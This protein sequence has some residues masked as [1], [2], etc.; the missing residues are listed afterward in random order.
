MTHDKLKHLLRGCRDGVSNHGYVCLALL[1][2]GFCY[3]EA[4]CPDEAFGKLCEFTYSGVYSWGAQANGELGTGEVSASHEFLPSVPFPKKLKIVAA[5]FHM[6]ISDNGDAYVLRN[7]TLWDKIETNLRFMS[8]FQNFMSD[9]LLL[10]VDGKIYAFDFYSGRYRLTEIV[11]ENVDGDIIT[12]RVLHISNSVF[13][14]KDGLY[15]FKLQ[16]DKTMEDYMLCLPATL[17]GSSQIIQIGFTYRGIDAYSDE[18]VIAALLS[19][20][21]LIMWGRNTGYQLGPNAIENEFYD[22]LN[23]DFVQVSLP[24][25]IDSFAIESQYTAAIANGDVY[26]WG[27]LFDTFSTSTPQKI[28]VQNV[29]F[30]RVIPCSDYITLVSTDGQVYS[31]GANTVGQLG[32]GTLQNRKVPVRNLKV[33]NGSTLSATSGSALL[34]VYDSEFL[35]WNFETAPEIPRVSDWRSVDAQNMKS[36]NVQSIVSGT[37]VT[38]LL[39]QSGA[40]FATGANNGMIGDGSTTR[41]TIPVPVYMQ[42]VM[43]NVKVKSL[44]VFQEVVFAIGEKQLYAWGAYAPCIHDGAAPLVPVEYS[45]AAKVTTVLADRLLL[46]ENGL[47]YS[48]SSK[49]QHEPA[50]LTKLAGVRFP[51]ASKLPQDTI[52]ATFVLFSSD[53]RVWILSQHLHYFMKKNIFQD[54]QV[55]NTYPIICRMITPWSTLEISRV[56]L[57]FMEDEYKLLVILKNGNVF[58]WDNYWQNYTSGVDPLLTT[59]NLLVFT[60]GSMLAYY[61]TSWPRITR[62]QMITPPITTNMKKIIVA[63]RTSYGVMA[64]FAKCTSNYTGPTCSQPVC[65]EIA[66]YGV[67]SG[68]GT[69]I[70]PQTCECHMLWEG[71]FCEVMSASA[72]A[73]I[74]VCSIVGGTLAIIFIVLVAVFTTIHCGR[75][76]RQKQVETEMKELLHQSLIRGDALAEQVDRDWVIPFVDLVFDERISEGSFGIVMRGRYQKGS[77]YV[78]L[79]LLTIR[80]IKII[81]DFDDNNMTEFEQ[82]VRILRSLRHP[83]IVL[84]MGVALTVRKFFTLKL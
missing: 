84:F 22:I 8:V 76:V 19:N 23:Q 54:C 12:E 31:F 80:A 44:E 59:E 43:K 82:E 50:N 48:C 34:F 67:C 57:W 46:A 37:Q 28:F 73:I 53:G 20:G 30:S 52:S 2:L 4:A 40:I 61:Q 62:I 81:K 7:K 18:G 55:E 5:S 29:K 10:T 25:K 64:V 63:A 11:I 47:L 36:Q 15:V 77:V 13:V 79:F 56:T 68:H 41:S 74:T 66:P 35:L 78:Y 14:N 69:C 24:Y 42:G 27:T 51:N 26:V 71:K 75:V 83:N 65:K 32:D 9:M 16:P 70:A 1:I 39:S 45:L 21:T 6:L 72:I 49:K 3:V 33:P 38:F 17:L 58:R 60:N